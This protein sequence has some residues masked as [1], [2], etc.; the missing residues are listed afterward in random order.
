MCHIV[1][2]VFSMSEKQKL[3]SICAI[4]PILWIK[5]ARVAP[6]HILTA[7]ERPVKIRDC[8]MQKVRWKFVQTPYLP[9]Q[10]GLKCVITNKQNGDL[11]L[12]SRSF[13]FLNVFD[14]VSRK[15]HWQYNIWSNPMQPDTSMCFW[16]C[17]VCY[18]I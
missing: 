12:C 9:Q 5:E 17:F 1:Q 4:L 3:L 13:C 14:G 2:C 10:H 15:I 16:T 8:H 18:L 6:K 7:K 11:K